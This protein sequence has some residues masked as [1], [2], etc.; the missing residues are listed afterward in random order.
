VNNAW[1]EYCPVRVLT[2]SPL[3][4][5]P[6]VFR[7]HERHAHRRVPRASD[8]L[9]DVRIG[10]LDVRLPGPVSQSFKAILVGY[11]RLVHARSRRWSRPRDNLVEYQPSVAKVAL[12]VDE[13]LARVSFHKAFSG[14]ANAPRHVSHLHCCVCLDEYTGTRESFEAVRSTGNPAQ[15]FYLRDRVLCRQVVNAVALGITALKCGG[16]GFGVSASR[17]PL[18]MPCACDASS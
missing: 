2:K 13:L 14:H 4:A 12:V 9:R 16:N 11:D 8:K 7:L 15:C 5:N 1:V 17:G 18:P 6:P 10:L 3:F